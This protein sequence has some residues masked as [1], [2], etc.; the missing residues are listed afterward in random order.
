[1][2]RNRNLSASRIAGSASGCS[3]G[4]V[5]TPSSFQLFIRKRGCNS[6][7]WVQRISISESGGGP[8]KPPT[9]WPM[10]NMPESDMPRPVRKFHFSESQLVV[11]SP[12]Q[13]WA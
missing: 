4:E 1:M 6:P 8:A 3:Q 2:S 13:V 9:S 11:L 12:L 7:T 10:L 5:V